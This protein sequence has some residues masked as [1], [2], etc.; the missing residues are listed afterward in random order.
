MTSKHSTDIFEIFVSTILIMIQN[1]YG[2]MVLYFSVPNN[3]FII[4]P[5]TF[6]FFI[7]TFGVY[8]LGWPKFCRR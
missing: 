1:A 4:L 6:I 2:M 3:V 5:V 8:L 7:K